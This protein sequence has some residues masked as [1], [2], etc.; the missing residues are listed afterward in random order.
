MV[1]NLIFYPS[2][3]L[4]PVQKTFSFTVT[5]GLLKAHLKFSSHKFII[6]M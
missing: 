1:A 2:I 4:F 5:L 3:Q 6:Y